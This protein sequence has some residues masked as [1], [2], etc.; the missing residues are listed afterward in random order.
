MAVHTLTVVVAASGRV[1]AARPTSAQATTEEPKKGPSPLAPEGHEL[2]WG[3]GSFVVFALIMR[4][5]LFPRLKQG[6]D[7]RYGK[8]RSDL[9]GADAT[10]AAAH[11]ELAE[12]HSAVAGLKAEAATRLDA[13]RTQ[14]DTE[15]SER[16]AAV[17]AG[18]AERKAQASADVDAAKAAAS[19]HV[20]EAVANVTTNA[21]RLLIGRVPDAAAVRAAV[22]DV[23]SVGAAR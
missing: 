15:R 22:A 6:M 4:F 3:A 8:I 18:I 19:G 1:Q 5:V 16:L 10:R 14:L 13:V 21:A 11:A 7:A 9:E 17:N 23:M 20:A 2:A 12:Y